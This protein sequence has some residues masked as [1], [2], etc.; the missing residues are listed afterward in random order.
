MPEQEIVQE[1][2]AG[3][4][5]SGIFA[6]FGWVLGFALAGK[7]FQIVL[8]QVSR[9]RRFEG[10]TALQVLFH[11][12][13]RPVPLLFFVFGLKAGL[14]A[15][16]P[17]G[18]VQE[19]A[20]DV[21][22]VMLVVA[23]TRFVYSL[24]DVVDHVLTVVT[25]RTRTK[26]DD[27]MAPLV[28][29]SL[30]AVVVVLA[31]VQTAQI[32]SDKPI[33][34][35][36]AGLGIGGLAIALAAQETIK[37][38]FGSLVVL[39]DKPFEL[40][41]RVKVGGYDGV[42]EEVGFRSTRIRTL[43]GHLVT[44][45]NGELANQMIEN[46]GRRPFIKRVMTVGITYGTPPEKVQKALD[47]LGEV[48]DGH[49]GMQPAFPPKIFFK[50]FSDSSLDLT[51]FYWYHPPDYWAYMRHAGQVNME[52]LKRF[53]EEGIE[54]AFPSRTLYFAGEA[55]EKNGISQVTDGNPKV[56]GT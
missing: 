56:S 18:G 9:S 41:E 42:V 55:P 33:T 27:M 54:F 49:E 26:M 19:L 21:L 10:R 40:D 51:A 12:L 25:S 39:A 4:T 24:V 35:I 43:K 23:L 38:F 3:L 6:L 14:S 11:A 30:R 37:N 8:S 44:L 32:L 16:A 47:I 50:D 29:K 52:V 48:L 5:R 20:E 1:M 15:L 28:C 46:V 7:T 22:A 31:L 13:A 36:I 2:A 45:P 34:S 17:G 53:N